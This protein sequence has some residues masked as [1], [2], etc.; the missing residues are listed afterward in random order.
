[1]VSVKVLKITINNCKYFF[2][3]CYGITHIVKINA[4]ILIFNFICKLNGSCLFNML[5]Q[6]IYLKTCI[7]FLLNKP[8]L[9]LI[10]KQ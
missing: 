1:M 3:L 4:S 5:T 9:D 6:T 8:T 10:L 2:Y 7:I